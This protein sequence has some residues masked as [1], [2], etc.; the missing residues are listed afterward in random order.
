MKRGIS[1]AYLTITIVIMIILASIV[2][3]NMDSAS[4]TIDTAKEAVFKADARSIFE[5]LEAEMS[6]EELNGADI[7]RESIFA[8]SLEDIQKYI[9]S[10]PAKYVGV[11]K[12]QEGKLVLCKEVEEE[13]EWVEDLAYID[14]EE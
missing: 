3:L 13:K 10:F 12:I 9:P 7:E 6:L 5:Q 14:I 11:Y 4:K 2:M 8:E 1:L